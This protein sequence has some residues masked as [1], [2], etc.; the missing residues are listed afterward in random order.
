MAGPGKGLTP[1]MEQ[2]NELKERHPDALLMVRLGDFYEL[3]NEDAKTASKEL[4]L[5]LTGREIGS[6]NRMPMCGVPH[7]AID[8]YLPQL[9]RKGYKVAIAE[10]LEDPKLAKGLVRRDITRVV[11]PGVLEGDDGGNNFM[12]SVYSDGISVGIAYCDA[13]T[14]EFRATQLDGEGA[15]AR[16][17]EELERLLPSEIVRA[18]GRTLPREVEELLAAGLAGVSTTERPEG[19]FDPRRAI[20]ALSA[21]FG[22]AGIEG[23]GLA[24]MPMAAAAAGALL[25]YLSFTQ[26]SD[27]GH[28]TSLGAYRI[29]GFMH[30]DRPSW[31]NLAVFGN[32]RAEGGKGLLGV[33]DRTST[34]M[35]AR[36]MR[37]WLEAPLVDSAQIS[38]R[39]DAVG[40]LVRDRAGA[41][42][43][44]DVLSGISDLERLGSKLAYSSAMPRDLAALSKSLKAA[45]R[46]KGMIEADAEAPLLLELAGSIEPSGDLTGELDAALADELPADLSSGGYIRPGYDAEV[47]GLRAAA[48]GGR[49]WLTS[50]EA[51]E[52]ERTGI[53][54]LRIG[55]NSVFGYYFEVSKSNIANVPSDF[56][57]KQTLAG[58]ERYYTEKLKEIE[59]KV[60]GAEEG[61]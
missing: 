52:R 27:L 41:D 56:I 24:G 59:T 58:S 13:S 43:L 40:E 11:S 46:L 35:G 23:F 32:D 53:K 1:M 3:F 57:R 50:L 14:G 25:S 48:A 26:K 61:K 47:D 6:G 22:T 38:R 29:S 28:I 20:R 34:K 51:K 42:K 60:L 2:Y 36:L 54:N 12:A 30:I 44:E 10:Q 37:A 21:H 7:H 15:A 55:Y 33:V 9:V 4:G 31:R 5:Y 17:R 19:D 16:A 45:G 39:Q 8:E 49:G 18:E